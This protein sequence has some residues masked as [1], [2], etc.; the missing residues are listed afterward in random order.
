[1]TPRPRHA[2]GFGGTY[3]AIGA[4]GGVA[5]GIGLLAQGK[6]IGLVALL[7]ASIFVRDA[8]LKY[9]AGNWP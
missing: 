7:L 8:Y 1:L 6:T 9:R 5:A 2:Q 4:L 3:N